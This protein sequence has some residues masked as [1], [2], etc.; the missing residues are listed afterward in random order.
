[1]ARLP[2]CEAWSRGIAEPL[3]IRTKHFDRAAGVQADLQPSRS[4]HHDLVARDRYLVF[5]GHTLAEDRLGPTATR[6]P[7]G[8]LGANVPKL[9]PIDWEQLALLPPLPCATLDTT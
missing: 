5:D 7:A 9:W 3:A 6:V 4:P 1:M 2:P 8:K